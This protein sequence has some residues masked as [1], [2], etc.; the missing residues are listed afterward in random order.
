MAPVQ[1]V[2]TLLQQL[3]PVI[4]VRPRQARLS[5]PVRSSAVERSLGIHAWL[6]RNAQS[7]WL[8]Q[9]RAPPDFCRINSVLVGFE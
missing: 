7:H 6:R 5:W 9:V 4:N 1:R 2:A 3:R 8:Y